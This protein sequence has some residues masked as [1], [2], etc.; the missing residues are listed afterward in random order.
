MTVMKFYAMDRIFDAVSE[1]L[2]EL[3]I[4][5]LITEGTLFNCSARIERH[6]VTGEIETK[7]NSTE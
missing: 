6:D 5:D 3:P 4:N 7:G 1:S 2:R